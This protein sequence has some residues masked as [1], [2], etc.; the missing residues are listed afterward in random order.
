MFSTSLPN[1]AAQIIDL[2][3]HESKKSSSIPRAYTEVSDVGLGLFASLPTSYDPST[4]WLDGSSPLHPHFGDATRIQCI[5]KEIKDDILAFALEACHLVLSSI[6]ASDEPNHSLLLET[7]SHYPDLWRAVL[8][9][10]HYGAIYFM[11]RSEARSKYYPLISQHPATVDAI[12]SFLGSHNASGTRIINYA[13]HAY[14]TRGGLR[15]D[16]A[17]SCVP[18]NAISAVGPRHVVV[19]AEDFPHRPASDV[20]ASS[21]PMWDLHD[22][23]HL[24][25]ATLCPELY[26]NKYQAHLIQLPKPLTALIRSPGMRSATGPKISDGL[27]FSELLTKLFSDAVAQG[28]P[29]DMQQQHRQQTYAGLTAKL[30]RALVEYLLGKRCLEHPSTGRMLSLPEPISPIQL[31]VLVQNK[32]YELPASEIEQRV[33]TRGGLVGAKEDVLQNLTARERAAWLAE[34]RTWGFFEVRNTIKH[35][36]HKEAYKLLCDVLM[37][38]AE[39]DWGRALLEKVRANILY[40]DWEKGRRVMLWDLVN[41]RVHTTPSSSKEGLGE[42]V[43]R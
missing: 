8:L 12:D 43:P 30:A 5:V 40:A 35:R 22:F 11:S 29:L 10:Q 23:A 13:V 37:E 7:L 9:A 27:V 31:A 3:R 34:S 41:H 28:P 19:R 14:I 16:Y 24:S 1:L 42:M 15:V 17:T 39:D 21:S 25:C 2:D 38:Q 4:Q 20:L 36:A 18:P 6:T 26:G 33:F 32:S